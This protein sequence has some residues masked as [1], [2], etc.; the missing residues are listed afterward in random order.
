MLRAE[1]Y[2]RLARWIGLE[3]REG[4]RLGLSTAAMC[5]LGSEHRTPILA[6]WNDTRA[7]RL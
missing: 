3:P 5:E 4:A 6:R 7:S 1:R 2:K